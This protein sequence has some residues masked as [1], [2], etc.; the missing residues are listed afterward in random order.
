MIFL[1]KTKGR[2]ASAA[3]WIIQLRGWRRFAI[4]FLCGVLAAMALAPIYAL[5][6]LFVGL[7]GLVWLL[8]GVRAHHKRA[9]FAG[10]AS[11]WWFGFGYFLASI[12]WM[13][14]S[15][16]VQADQFAL[17][18]PLALF[19]LPAFLGLFSAVAVWGAVRFWVP[20]WSRV[21]LLAACL[22]V[23]EYVR[24]HILTGLPWNLISQSLAGYLPLAQLAAV[25]G[26]YGLSFI[27]LVLGG[28]PA[29]MVSGVN[30]LSG[31]IGWKPLW[32]SLGGMVF[33]ALFGFVR[34][35]LLPTD[36]D[37]S[38]VVQIVQPNIPQ[39]EK[40]NWDYWQRNFMRALDL[41]LPDEPIKEDQTLLIVWPENAA[42]LLGETENAR[43]IL[44]DRLPAGAVLLAGAVRR[45]EPTREAHYY[46]A[47]LM[48]HHAPD[49]TPQGAGFAP[50]MAVVDQYDKAH[51]VPFGEY[52]PLYG[53]LEKIGL[54]SLAPIE[55]GFTPGSG[56][57]NLSF[58]SKTGR[59]VFSPL[60]CY[61]IIFPGRLYPRGQRPD[62][63]VTIT[64]DAW[65]GDSAGPRQHL[66]QARMRAIESGLPI[67]RS[68]NTGISALIDA[69]GR[70]VG[71]LA[72]YEAGSIGNM[73]P[74][75]GPRTLYSYFGDGLFGLIL[76][77]ALYYFRFR[78]TG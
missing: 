57:R 25:V 72:L 37:P 22:S 10:F 7:S 71:R 14:F 69:Q 58:D 77:A 38:V 48:L 12:Y 42:A 51:L 74:M 67:V 53:L 66:D 30:G 6:L 2:I 27:V 63:I 76:L 78:R 65:F 3:N 47:L 45:D 56:R 4:A 40:I 20:H 35:A 16:F 15:F 46:N 55:E 70:M 23:A 50:P 52:L 33:L 59:K 26:P 34:L 60:I 31:H 13:S 39:K 75:T 62:F 61:E 43:G 29:T 64:N 44:A 11:G 28:L 8:D 19:G 54:T 68:A 17:L 18:S 73:M 21:L 1:E 24:G 9:R 5:P 32:A 41:S 49:S 36:N